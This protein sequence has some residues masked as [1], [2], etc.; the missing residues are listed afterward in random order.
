MK[1]K[2]IFIALIAML[3]ITALVFQSCK[4]E[5]EKTNQAPTCQIT[6]PNNGQEFTQGENIT[7]SVNAEDTDG[8]ITEVRFFINDVGKGSANSF[9]YNY[10]WNTSGEN[11]GNYT[12]KATSYDND[13][14]NSSDEI[15]IKLITGSSGEAPIAIFSATPTSGTAPLNVN[16]TD[17][18]QN[19][20]TSWFWEFG[21][22]NN[23]SQQNPSHTYYN[24]G[25]YTLSLTVENEDGSD[26]ETKI[27]YVYV[28]N[29]GGGGDLEWVNVSGGT[30]QMGSNE[31]YSNELPIHNVTLSSYEITKYEI[32]NG[33][34]CEFLNN[35]GCN[36]NGSY[37]GTKYIDMDNSDSQIN[38]TGGQF[39]PESGITD[40]PVIRVSWYGSNAFAR[41]AGGR[42]PTEAEWE[43][44]ARGG[45]NSNGY[46][47]SGSNTVGE[48]AWYGGNSGNNTHQV[49]TKAT[50]ELGIHDMSGNVW[51]WCN[52]WYGSDYYSSSPS[53]NPQGPSSG[54]YRVG[55]GGCWYSDYDFCLVATRGWLNPGF[56]SQ[57]GGF[58]V[59][60]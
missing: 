1:V 18:S 60:R 6:A 27:D 51:E 56:T 43:F 28:N 57:T 8:S 24:E 31:G 50:N 9:P 25:N 22:G 13:G 26:T 7:I 34:Y 11:M 19:N 36:S 48:V 14:S 21:D 59:A 44:A 12:L 23:S 35:I 3:A 39:V 41:W 53:N 4:K 10:I 40:F 5:E 32:T 30:F 20:P 49:G 55:R 37:N 2:T 47:Y 15:S 17:Q 38:Y 42:L 54:V 16:F 33:Q 52:D 29:G 46:I 58:R 45:N